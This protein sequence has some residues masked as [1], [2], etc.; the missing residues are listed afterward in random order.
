MNQNSACTASTL[1]NQEPWTASP[2]PVVQ[3]YVCMVFN[4]SSVVFRKVYPEEHKH[5]FWYLVGLNILISFNSCLQS[6]ASQNL[7][8]MHSGEP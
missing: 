6:A 7:S 1:F 8:H 5:P 4:N 2:H 3:E